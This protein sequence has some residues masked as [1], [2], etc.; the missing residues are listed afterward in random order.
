MLIFLLLQEKI[1]YH[2]TP[3]ESPSQV[4]TFNIKTFDLRSGHCTCVG[5]GPFG[6]RFSC[7]YSGPNALCI[8]D[9]DDIASCRGT[10]NA[11]TA[12]DC[13]TSAA[14]AAP[15]AAAAAAALANLR[16]ALSKLFQRPFGC[17][18]FSSCAFS[19]PEYRSCAYG[20]APSSLCLCDYLDD[21]SCSGT[22]RFCDVGTCA[23]VTP[24]T[25]PAPIIEW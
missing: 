21:G 15:A 4:L 9:Y 16:F 14:P 2:N 17:A 6:G 23:P 18:P 19:F 25:T 7:A 22:C 1:Y 20:T 12:R 10:C 8:C 24:A 11:C 5:G 3:F 13:A